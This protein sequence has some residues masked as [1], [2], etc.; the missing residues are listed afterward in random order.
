MVLRDVVQLQITDR[1]C[2]RLCDKADED[3]NG[4]LDFCEFA[5]LISVNSTPEGA[6]LGARFDP[7]MVRMI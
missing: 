1:Y 7:K 2:E 3:G 6:G 4:E 5:K